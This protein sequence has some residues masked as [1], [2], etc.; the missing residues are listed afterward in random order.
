[1]PDGC[2]P[3]AQQMQRLL[4][5]TLH[6]WRIVEGE[7]YGLGIAAKSKDGRMICR[8]MTREADEQR[9]S[10][11]H[12]R[13]AAE[14]RWKNARRMPGDAFRESESPRIRETKNQ[15]SD[16]GAFRG[17]KLTGDGLKRRQCLD[18]LKARGLTCKHDKPYCAGACGLDIREETPVERGPRQP[19][20]K[21]EERPGGKTVKSYKPRTVGQIAAALTGSK[22]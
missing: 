5:C 17:A 20:I 3:N 8:R 18:D 19:V 13:K 2:P 9:A 4:G 22:R 7:L 16:T 21:T 10:S 11:L 12:G 6:E 1:M 15:E 14:A